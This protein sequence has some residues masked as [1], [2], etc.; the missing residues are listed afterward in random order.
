M[1]IADTDFEK[2][3]WAAFEAL[4][5]DIRAKIQN[6]EIQVRAQ[7]DAFELDMAGEDDPRCCSAFTTARR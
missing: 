4:P 2:L 3:V 1:H 7:P 6:L 5:A